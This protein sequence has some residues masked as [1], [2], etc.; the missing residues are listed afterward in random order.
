MMFYHE[1]LRRYCFSFL[2]R[3][4]NAL[5]GLIKRGFK[6]G[7]NKTRLSI[8]TVKKKNL[9]NILKRHH[10][11]LPFDMKPYLQHTQT[12]SEEQQQVPNFSMTSEQAQGPN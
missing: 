3:E 12:H 5:L 1:K 4:R 9:S 8:P 2:K 6:I 11:S 10:F 7:A